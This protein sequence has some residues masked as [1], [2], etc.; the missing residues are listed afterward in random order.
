MR[1]RRGEQKEP[2][3]KKKQRAEAAER[4]RDGGIDGGGGRRGGGRTA[5]SVSSCAPVQRC[6]TAQYRCWTGR[7]T[8]P[9][10]ATS[11][12]SGTRRH[13]PRRPRAP[14]Q[15]K[16]G[17]MSSPPTSQT[18]HSA[19]LATGATKCLQRGSRQRKRGPSS[20]P[21]TTDTGAGSGAGA[22]AVG[23]GAQGRYFAVRIWLRG[24]GLRQV[25]V[26][27]GG[28]RWPGCWQASP[29]HWPA[30]ARS[31]RGSRLWLPES[32]AWPWPR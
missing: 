32:H 3:K 21:P 29:R 13:V 25:L 7:R 12:A 20:A 6:G 28:Q 30:V 17:A 18:R 9:C 19:V 4:R 22:G 15:Y 8:G 27:E 2:K 16:R 10:T 1:R 11:R 26:P 5:L 14:Q 24:A 23:G 31:C